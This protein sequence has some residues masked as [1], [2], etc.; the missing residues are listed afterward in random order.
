MIKLETSRTLILI[1][2]GIC[3]LACNAPKKLNTKV[4]CDCEK[5]ADA[6]VLIDYRVHTFDS[7]IGP[8]VEWS[9]GT[10]EENEEVNTI[11]KC[12]DLQ[13]SYIK[14]RLGYYAISDSNLKHVEDWLQK[15]CTKTWSKVPE[16][17][18]KIKRPKTDQYEI[19][20]I[21]KKKK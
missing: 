14:Y 8:K 16:L 17:K 21:E 10:F 1:L 9:D 5:V 19:D 6:Y 7:I 20:E 13:L 3:Y 18:E 2:F 11:K 15:N 12:T 4:K